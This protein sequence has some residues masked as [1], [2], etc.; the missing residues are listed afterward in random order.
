MSTAPRSGAVPARS[1]IS[2]R[3][4]CAS[5]TP[6]VWM[7]TSA[8]RV[9]SGFASMI[10]WAIRVSVRRR[11]SASRR[12][13]PAGASTA[14]TGWAASTV[15]GQAASCDSFPASL[16]RLKGFGSRGTLNA[17]PDGAP[18][19]RPLRGIE[20]TRPRLPGQAEVGFQALQSPRRHN[21]P[22]TL[23]IA[24]YE[25]CLVDGTFRRRNELVGAPND[26]EHSGIDRRRRSEHAARQPAYDRELEPGAPVRAELRAWPYGCA[27]AR[28]SPVE[29]HVCTLQRHQWIEQSAEDRRATS[30]GKVR[31]DFELLARE[32]NPQHVVFD[33]ADIGKA[34]PETGD[35]LGV[36]LNRDHGRSAVDESS[37]QD[38]SPGTEIENEVAGL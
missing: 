14:L 4:R 12:T 20:V 32:R 9:R 35:E 10:S 1:S 13:R 28:D 3:R 26:S 16:D 25:K 15:C 29:D 37:C 17:L 11:A 6:R 36:D 24:T 2:R 38:A 31:H 33:D 7:P 27:L 18:E 8:T 19:A 5:G 23:A 34:T 22:E 30:E 21:R